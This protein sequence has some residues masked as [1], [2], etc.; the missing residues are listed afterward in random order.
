MKNVYSKI[1]FFLVL[2]LPGIL[3]SQSNV[4]RID[5]LLNSL[6]TNEAALRLFFSAMPKGGDLHHHYSGSIYAEKYIEKAKSANAWVNAVTLEIKFDSSGILKDKE[7]QKFLTLEKELG[8]YNFQQILLK[9]FSSKDY[10]RSD[11]ITSY[12]DF[13]E[14]FNRFGSSKNQIS[15]G[16]G[17]LWLKQNAIQ[18]NVSYIE[19][20]LETIPCGTL[21]ERFNHLNDSLLLYQASNDTTKLFNLFNTLKNNLL[22]ANNKICIQ[23]Y[24]KGLEKEHLRLQIDD[25]LFTLRYQTYVLRILPPIQ[26][27]SQMITSFEAA[28]E[29]T[30]LVGINMVAP[31]HHPIALRDYRLHMRMFQYCAK[32]WPKVSV[33]LHAGELSEGLVSPENMRF[34]IKEAV[35]IGGAKRI[36]HGT[37]LAY[38]QDVLSLIERMRAKKTVIEIN[39]HSNR[40]ILGSTHKNHPLYLYH[41]ANIPIV[42]C[43]DDAGVLRT[44]HNGE[45]IQIA[46]DFPSLTYNDFKEFA[47]NSINHSFIKGVEVRT[48]LLEKL[49]RDFTLFENDFLNRHQNIFKN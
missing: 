1:L 41:K 31:E 36:G 39:Y 22:S 16:S 44:D 33:S 25:S 38:E 6:R 49:Q 13:F 12:D 19:T 42:I 17:L 48:K 15:N 3:I 34:H 29:D 40:F 23:N 11:G 35:D 20:M 27:L 8:E 45:F 10:S 28:K 26:V 7:W 47:F 24:L 32:T 18:Q 2:S 5:S 37:A 14:T 21:P 30:L 4:S 9:H 43:T 46:L